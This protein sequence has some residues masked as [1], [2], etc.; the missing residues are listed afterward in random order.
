LPD[1][2]NLRPKYSLA[3]ICGKGGHVLSLP[4]IADHHSSTAIQLELDLSVWSLHHATSYPATWQYPHRGRGVV[5]LPFANLIWRWL[6]EGLTTELFLGVI[7]AL[8]DALGN[9]RTQLEQ[10]V[11]G[12]RALR[13][14][15]VI[16]VVGY[17]R[18]HLAKHLFGH[19]LLK[20]DS[21]FLGF[22]FQLAHPGLSGS[23]CGRHSVWFMGLVP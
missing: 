6:R 18:D 20:G 9:G 14:T 4:L 19:V 21:E 10:V 12:D 13:S 2:K 8:D 16:L 22:L 23:L 17:L 7:G 11:L 15:F 5:C 3:S 1:K